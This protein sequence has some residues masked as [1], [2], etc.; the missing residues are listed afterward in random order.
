MILE[1]ILGKEEVKEFG[2]WYERHLNAILSEF[3][4]FFL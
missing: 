1:E 4:S 2:V 3:F